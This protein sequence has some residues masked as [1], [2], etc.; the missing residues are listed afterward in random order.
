MSDFAF[1]DKEID[2]AARDRQRMADIQRDG[3]RR[4]L[5]HLANDSERAQDYCRALIRAGADVSDELK[6]METTARALL[7]VA[8]ILKR[9][10]NRG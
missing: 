9:E 7:L 4:K 8:M 2:R 6:D 3:F 5:L 1:L 10:T